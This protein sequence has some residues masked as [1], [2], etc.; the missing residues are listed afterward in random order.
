ML[1]VGAGICGLS[2]ALE[3]LAR[4]L[5]FAVVERQHVG[6]GASGRNA[7]FLMRGMAENYA[8]ACREHGR[9][10][11]RTMWQWTE[12][13][14][15]INLSRGAGG[16][17]SFRPTPSCLLAL[18]SDERA[19]LEES[20]T[21]LRAD[22]FAA[23][24]L[25]RHEDG[26]WARSGA[27]GGLVN[28]ADASVNPWELL[29]H[30]ASSLAG[31][32]F[33]GQEVV[34]I[35]PGTA[36]RGVLA[37][38]TDGVFR[39]GRV[40]VCTNAYAGLLLPSLAG[41]V[42]PNRGQMLAIAPSGAYRLDHAYYANRGSEYFRQTPDGTVVVGGKR[43]VDPAAERGRDDAPTG[44]VQ[45]ELERFAREVL[46][47]EGR[48][49]A[50]WAGTMGFSVDGLPVVGRVGVAGVEPDGVWFCGGF[51][52]HGMSLAARTARAAVEQLLDGTPTPF[53][54]ERFDRSG[55]AR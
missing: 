5:R 46:G 13:N 34:S 6:A 27:L 36:G 29:G 2:C 50:R 26:A 43:G 15:R 35:E 1:V 31:A 14:L 41:V 16:L 20:L 47:L 25:H 55:G 28:P 30:L 38:T 40:L 53:G 48:V 12:E 33:E 49:V 45:M 21:L 39:A 54:I 37:R 7:G 22:G 42:E 10:R 4:G 24:W 52:G 11:A 8:V 17:A 18:R 9:A 51:T 44:S 23:E 32:I 19:E 3:L